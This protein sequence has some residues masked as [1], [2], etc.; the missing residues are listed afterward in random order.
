MMNPIQLEEAYRDFTENFQKWAPD[1]FI[2][3]NLQLLQELGLLSNSELEIS[4]PESL[5]QQFHVIETSEKVTLFNKQFAVWIIPQTDTELPSTLILIALIQN[6]KPHLEI[7]Y[8]TSGVYNTPKYILRILQHF[9]TEVLDTEAI[10]SSINK[11][12]SS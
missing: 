9:L 6:L 1:G 12:K 4:D 8:T 11:K 7:V 3:V 2:N 10:L 5:S